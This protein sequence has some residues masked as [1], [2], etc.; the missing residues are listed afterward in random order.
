MTAD[1]PTAS[2]DPPVVHPLPPEAYSR[3]TLV[4]RLGLGISL[5]ILAGGVVAYLLLN[6]GMSSSTLLS[7]NPILD[8]LDLPGL[9]SGL[10]AG[11][12]SAVL[13]L[14]LIVLVATPIVR[15]ASGLYFFGKAG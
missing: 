13:T 10:A 9:A 14:G 5:T 4:L 3:M 11:S 6:P 1:S 2:G 8:Y 12:V 7:S 15:V